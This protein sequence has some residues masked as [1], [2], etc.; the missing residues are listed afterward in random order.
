MEG[1][2]ILPPLSLSSSSCPCSPHRTFSS[3][4]RFPTV[5]RPCT[6]RALSRSGP[7][8]LPLQSS[9]EQKSSAF[10]TQEGGALLSRA[11]LDPE[12][13][14][15]VPMTC[16]AWRTVLGNLVCF[17]GQLTPFYPVDYSVDHRGSCGDGVLQPGEECDDGNDDV[18]D[19]CISEWGPARSL[20][21]HGVGSGQ[22][23]DT[24]VVWDNF[25]A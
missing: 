17:F 14:S 19:D 18:G 9:G 25:R 1:L 10:P 4:P 2:S 11:P 12:L 15:P 6:A 21:C 22:A 13:L 3:E 16:P 23:L 20:N 5:S 7:G 8:F 24:W